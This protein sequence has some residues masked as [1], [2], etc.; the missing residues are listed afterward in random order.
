MNSGAALIAMAHIQP[1]SIDHLARI[2]RESGAYPSG[3]LR[4][5]SAPDPIAGTPVRQHVNV[6]V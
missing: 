5:G 4:A 2:R 1:R 3:I 6:E